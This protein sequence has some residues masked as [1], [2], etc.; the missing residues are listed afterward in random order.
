MDSLLSKDWIFSSVITEVPDTTRCSLALLKYTKFIWIGT[1][2]KA[3]AIIWILNIQ[4]IQKLCFIASFPFGSSNYF[5]VLRKKTF[6][7]TSHVQ[8]L[9]VS[10]T[11]CW[12]LSIFRGKKRVFRP[13][14]MEE[15]KLNWRSSPNIITWPLSGREIS[16]PPSRSFSTN[17][18]CHLSGT[19]YF[20]RIVTWVMSG[21]SSH[22]TMKNRNRKWKLK[23]LT[24]DASSERVHRI[25]YYTNLLL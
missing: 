1:W 8:G 18:L 22:W 21:L 11:W 25:F 10:Y 24:W 7:N 6:S 15:T 20:L 16:L 13:Q 5:L 23:T 17:F 12:N 19:W 3:I 4:C 14:R 2:A 9:A